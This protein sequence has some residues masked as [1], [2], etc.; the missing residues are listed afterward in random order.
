MQ[1]M[2]RIRLLLVSGV[3]RI[4]DGVIAMNSGP[5]NAAATPKPSA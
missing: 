4:P 5:L 2:A 1:V 3:Y